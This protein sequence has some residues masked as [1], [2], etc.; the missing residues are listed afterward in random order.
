MVDTRLAES[1]MGLGDDDTIENN[2]LHELS[3]VQKRNDEALESNDVD[4][5]YN[6]DIDHGT[7]NQK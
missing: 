1:Q 2:N 6:Q 4:S 3:R 7:N 5:S